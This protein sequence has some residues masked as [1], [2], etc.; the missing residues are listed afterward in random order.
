MADEVLVRQAEFARRVGCSRGR[1]SQLIGEGR[2]P[3][4]QVGKL[5]L[6][7]WAEGERCWLLHRAVA[8]GGPPPGGAHA[9]GPG[10]ADDLTADW[11]PSGWEPDWRALE[12]WDAPLDY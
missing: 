12:G 1:V 7:P 4:V 3:T 10:A 2:L 9:L 5:R 11:D 6:I 8:V